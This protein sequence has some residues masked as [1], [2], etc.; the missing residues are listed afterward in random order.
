V[1]EVFQSKAVV[2]ARAGTSLGGSNAVPWR[3]WRNSPR[4]VDLMWS[5][6]QAL[7]KPE[8]FGPQSAHWLRL[9]EHLNRISITARVGLRTE[10]T[11]MCI[12]R[13]LEYPS[14]SVR[15]LRGEGKWS[16]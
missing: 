16:V 7:A 9:P 15:S 6:A 4:E 1:Q 12:D 3:R 13:Q 14:W 2:D 10:Y 11:S 5:T 8:L